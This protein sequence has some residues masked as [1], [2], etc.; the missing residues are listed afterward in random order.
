[1]ALNL[2][3][4][5]VVT[6][7][8]AP[9]VPLVD[10]LSDEV[11]LRASVELRLS[12]SVLVERVVFSSHSGSA[13][14]I[15]ATIRAVL[16]AA[17]SRGKGL[18]TKRAVFGSLR[19]EVV[20]LGNNTRDNT[21]AS[22]RVMTSRRADRYS[23]ALEFCFGPF[24]AFAADRALD[25]EPLFAEALTLVSVLA[26]SAAELPPTVLES[27][28]IDLKNASTTADSADKLSHFWFIKPEPEGF[29]KK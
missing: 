18:T 23:S 15:A 7:L 5:A 22:S 1:M 19:R 17:N 12:S 4:S 10:L 9:F 29:V 3:C 16:N 2:F 25:R 14:K 24:E 20:W 27:S 11:P 6:A 28:F 8:L 21:S 13:D 26:F